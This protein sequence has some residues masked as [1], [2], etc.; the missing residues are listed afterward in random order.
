MR[1]G[2]PCRGACIGLESSISL[3]CRDTERDM[4]DGVDQGIPWC[5]SERSLL[6]YSSVDTGKCGSI[7]LRNSVCPQIRTF[8]TVSSRVYGSGFEVIEARSNRGGG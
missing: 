6:V 3:S 5:G 7:F 1:G 4:R 8:A 2:V